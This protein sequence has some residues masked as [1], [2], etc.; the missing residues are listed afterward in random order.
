M[1]EVMVVYHL[2]DPSIFQKKRELS[3]LSGSAKASKRPVDAIQSQVE[4]GGV[5]LESR[6]QT[7]ACCCP[8]G[9]SAGPEGVV[10]S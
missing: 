1:N 3:S 4:A 5:G 8:D 9:S 10:V 7:V 6:W 2:V